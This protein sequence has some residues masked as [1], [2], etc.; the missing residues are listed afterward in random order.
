MHCYSYDLKLAEKL[1]KEN[2]TL[3]IGGILTFKKE[4][5]LKKIVKK[6][7]I[8]NFLLETDSPYL[9][10]EPLRGHINEPYNIT[11]I[12]KTI[13]QIK[14]ISYEKVLEETTNNAKRQFGLKI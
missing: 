8:S 10:P 1:T 6:L 12:A 11:Y 9:T 14:D 3:G 5:N 13:A 4:E 2:I 7:D